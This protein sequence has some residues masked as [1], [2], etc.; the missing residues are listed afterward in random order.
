MFTKT[1]FNI[2]NEESFPIMVSYS[3]TNGYDDDMIPDTT[4]ELI[5]I[6]NRRVV[7]L[8]EDGICEV[9]ILGVNHSVR[10]TEG[11]IFH[12]HSTCMEITYCDRGSVKFDCGGKVYS[13]LPGSVFVSKPEDVH[14]LRTNPKGSRIYWLFLRLPDPGRPFLGLPAEE[15]KWLVEE[16]ASFPRKAFSVPVG[17][18]A[19]FERLFSILDSEPPKSVRRTVKLR[20][21]VLSL[22]MT[23]AESGHWKTA[24]G[25]N[26][27]FRSVIESMRHDP[28]AAYSIEFLAKT[29]G[30]SPNTVFSHFRQFTGL[31]PQ[32]FLMKCRIHR[33]Q[34]ILSDGSKRI[35][36]V[37]LDLGF[38][39][40]QHFA[41]RFRQEVGVSPSEWRRKTSE[42]SDVGKVQ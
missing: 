16:L 9:P 12:R 22:L 26:E 1:Q 8:S 32:A 28:C 31:P 30:C 21:A 23:L 36:D 20:A 24:V 34:D 42:T 33:A 10:M 4:S 7:D 17:M 41:T 5:D 29:L 6:S 19:A 38:S 37:A 13:L 40:S 39:S 11:S 3:N 14:R 35:T 25:I 27:R 2:V 18:K 15:G